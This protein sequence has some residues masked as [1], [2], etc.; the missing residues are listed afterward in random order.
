MF[1]APLFV[2]FVSMVLGGVSVLES[3]LG[4]VVVIAIYPDNVLAIMGSVLALISII[5]FSKVKTPLA[6][7]FG[8][9]LLSLIPRPLELWQAKPLSIVFKTCIPSI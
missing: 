2:I 9:I 1:L 7:S 3:S 4:L 8:P 6:N 5:S